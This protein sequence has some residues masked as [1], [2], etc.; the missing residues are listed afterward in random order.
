MIRFDEVSKVFYLEIEK[1]TF[2]TLGR[3]PPVCKAV[4]G[5]VL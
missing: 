2:D 1:T 3:I 4:N 5:T